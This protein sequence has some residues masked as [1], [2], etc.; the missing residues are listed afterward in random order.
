LDFSQRQKT[1]SELNA[2]ILLAQS[3]EKGKASFSKN[4]ENVVYLSIY[5][6]DAC[7]KGRSRCNKWL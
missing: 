2:A 7:K 1:A 5:L 4:A 6:Y 3:Q